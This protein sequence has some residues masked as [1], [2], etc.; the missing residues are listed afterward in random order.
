MNI[1]NSLITLVLLSLLLL[2]G[3]GFGCGS[4]QTTPPFIG[5]WAGPRESRWIFKSD[6]TSLING[7]PATWKEN[8]GTLE[9]TTP[10]ST[11]KMTPTYGSDNKKLTLTPVPDGDPPMPPT[12]FDRVQ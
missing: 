3:V 2:P 1:R 11:Y 12:S 9:I 4:T 6:G 7:Q 5:T 10:R 8:D